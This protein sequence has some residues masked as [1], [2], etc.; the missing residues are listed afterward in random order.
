MDPLALFELPFFAKLD[1]YLIG[2]VWTTQ[3][4]QRMKSRQN[5]PRQLIFPMSKY[6][7]CKKYKV[8]YG[9]PVNDLKNMGFVV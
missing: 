9:A 3:F 1:L 2:G 5:W 6:F 4:K 8:A 7:S